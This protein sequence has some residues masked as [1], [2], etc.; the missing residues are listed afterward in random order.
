MSPLA[1]GAVCLFSLW[2]ATATF[3]L[4]LVWSWSREQRRDRRIEAAVYRA[5]C[6]RAQ[7]EALFSA[8][9]FGEERAA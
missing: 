9:A 7:L 5:E 1:F 8:P 4:V 6:E 2:G 3:F